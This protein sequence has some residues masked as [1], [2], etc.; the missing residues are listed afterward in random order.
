MKRLKEKL[1]ETETEI[2]TYCLKRGLPINEESSEI[3]HKL[4]IKAFNTALNVFDKQQSI[5]NQANDYIMALLKEKNTCE[6]KV[7]K[8]TKLIM[9]RK[10]LKKRI[11]KLWVCDSLACSNEICI[12]QIAELHSEREVCNEHRCK[13]LLI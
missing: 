3:C 9:K 11:G 7:D 4:L 1:Q 10:S 12:F 13:H 5:P 6:E 8:F 2:S